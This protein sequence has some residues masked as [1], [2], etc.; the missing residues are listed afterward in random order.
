MDPSVEID[1]PGAAPTDPASSEAQSPLERV[2]TRELEDAK[3]R[4][5]AVSRL[6]LAKKLSETRD[7]PMKDALAMVDAFCEREQ[8]YLPEYLKS[9]FLIG[10]M[11]VVAIFLA[12]ASFGVIVAAIH[13][14]D[15]GFRLGLG[16]MGGLLI[17]VAAGA[18]WVRSLR[19]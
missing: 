4:Q 2:L 3:E 12:I 16:I 1:R 15:P 9:E 6:S 18:L 11:K 7:I 5:R 19:G 13:L 17:M 8:R 14:A 10:W